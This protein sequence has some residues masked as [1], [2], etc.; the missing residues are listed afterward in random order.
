MAVQKGMWVG[1]SSCGH[2]E[3]FWE[4]ALRRAAMETCSLLARERRLDCR[5]CR[6]GV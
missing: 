6:V 5:G 3:G 4:A 1:A 2:E